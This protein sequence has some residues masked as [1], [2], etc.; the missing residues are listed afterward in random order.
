VFTRRDRTLYQTER[1][2]IMSTQK[3]SPAIGRGRL[4]QKSLVSGFVLA[5]Y[6]AYAA[7]ERLAASA[8]P[9]AALPPS[10]SSS[11]IAQAQPQDQAAASASAQSSAGSSAAPQLASSGQYR[12]GTYTG[13][14]ANAFYGQVQVQV[15]IAN[16]KITSVTFLNYPQDRRTSARINSYAVPQLQ[17][18]AV[19]AQSANVDIV[20]GATLTSEAF[21]QSL[22]SALNS[23]QG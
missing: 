14:T 23:A 4:L 1:I 13:L 2:N 16:G 18:E 8:Q 6:L 12:D 9:L 21:M 20:S 15:T 17:S 22:Q 3:S 10:T 11:Q 5:S 19:Q 7:H